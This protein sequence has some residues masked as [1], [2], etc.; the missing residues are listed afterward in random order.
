MVSVRV[1]SRKCNRVFILRDR[2]AYNNKHNIEH[3]VRER[4]S[5]Y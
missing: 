3:R 2:S 4:L 5:H 1:I